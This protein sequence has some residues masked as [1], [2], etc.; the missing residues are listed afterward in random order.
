MYYQWFPSAWGWSQAV[1]LLLLAFSSQK[2]CFLST[3][4]AGFY[5]SIPP[6]S[7]PFIWLHVCSSSSFLLEGLLIAMGPCVAPVL[8]SEIFLAIRRE[9]H[10]SPFL[11]SLMPHKMCSGSF[12]HPGVTVYF[13]TYVSLYPLFNL[14]IIYPHPMTLH[15]AGFWFLQ[16][17]MAT[18]T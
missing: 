3:P 14:F 12:S 11:A 4:G 1:T 8:K 17:R 16:S 15:R 13:Y 9:I 10:M 2:S 18:D 6:P 5:L 7:L